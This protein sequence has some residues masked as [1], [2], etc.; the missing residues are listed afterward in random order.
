SD[1][2]IVVMS[3]TLD[4]RSVARFLDDAPVVSVPGALHPLTIEYA[5]GESVADAARA[6]LSRTA[7]QVLCFLPGAR[8]IERAGAELSS[9]SASGV[10]VVPLHGSLDGDVQDAAISPSNVRR[11]I[12]A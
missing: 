2:R 5:E 8:E 4:V 12:L 7:G 6:V 10:A 1:L 11:I 9:M 3:A